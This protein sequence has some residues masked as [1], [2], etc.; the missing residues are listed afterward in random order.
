[1]ATQLEALHTIAKISHM[2]DRA[3]RMSTAIRR[4]GIAR[5]EIEGI[6]GLSCHSGLIQV[7]AYALEDL[8]RA[9]LVALPQ[10]A[11]EALS[12]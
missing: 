2:G 3:V 9:G 10:W 1:M 6:R 4:T 5:D 11:E 12:E 8:A 7:G